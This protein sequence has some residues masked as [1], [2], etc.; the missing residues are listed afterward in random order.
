M[1]KFI[2]IISQVYLGTPKGDKEVE[3]CRLGLARLHA[4]HLE[5]FV[6]QSKDIRSKK[7]VLT[8]LLA[9]VIDLDDTDCHGIQLG[10]SRICAGRIITNRSRKAYNAFGDFIIS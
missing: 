10:T 3:H 8:T 6:L 4:K 1:T 5:Q 2:P 9:Y 7:Y